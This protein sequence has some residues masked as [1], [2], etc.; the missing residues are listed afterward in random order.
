MV[1]SP[2]DNGKTTEPVYPPALARDLASLL[3]PGPT[4]PPEVNEAV[5]NA[6]RTQFTHQRRRRLLLRLAPL[7]AAAAAAIALIM[8][9][10]PTRYADQRQAES[11]EITVIPED[12]DRNGHVDILDAFALARRIEADGVL[13]LAWD[14]NGDGEVDG[15]DVDTVAMTAVRIN[16][17]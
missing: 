11:H 4:V 8:L 3:G 14:I 9:S 10:L 12:I 15:G 1:N 16:G 7:G 6:A 2:R 17:G 5:I 13:G